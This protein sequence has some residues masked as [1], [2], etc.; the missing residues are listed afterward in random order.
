MYYFQYRIPHEVAGIQNDTS[1]TDIIILCG[2]SSK[3]HC[4][5]LYVFTIYRWMDSLVRSPM[6]WQMICYLEYKLTSVKQLLLSDPL[7][8]LPLSVLTEMRSHGDF[9]YVDFPF[10]VAKY[11]LNRDMLHCRFTYIFCSLA[12][13]ISIISRIELFCHFSPKDIFQDYRN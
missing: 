7:T 11:N 12:C 4:V 6:I 10:D 3:L 8:H 13:E 2:L 1:P 5:N 9:L